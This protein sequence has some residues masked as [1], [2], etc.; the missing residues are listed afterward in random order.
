M[1]PTTEEWAKLTPEEDELN[2]RR[3]AR[4]GAAL[5]SGWMIRQDPVRLEFTAAREMH[6]ART[7]DALLDAVEGA[8]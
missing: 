6:T 3:L 5:R 2:A 1:G 7:L 4:I 8:G